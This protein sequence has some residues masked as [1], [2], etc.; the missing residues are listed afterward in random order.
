[1]ND[2]LFT[3]DT[4]KSTAFIL[5]LLVGFSTIQPVLGSHKRVESK[6]HKMMKCPRQ[7][8]PAGKETDN[9]CNPFMSCVYGNF[10]FAEKNIISFEITIPVIDKIAATNDNRLSAKSSECWHPPEGTA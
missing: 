3:F 10:Y 9:A 5:L 8:E 6:C 7:K 1:M 4:K 2:Y